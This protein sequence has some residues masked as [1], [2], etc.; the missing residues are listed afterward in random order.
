MNKYKSHCCNEKVYAVGGGYRVDADNE[1]DYGL[2][3]RTKYYECDRCKES[4]DAI[5]MN[6][7]E[8]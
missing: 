6:E 8:E 5:L 7:D 4:C 2:K 3:I 1:D